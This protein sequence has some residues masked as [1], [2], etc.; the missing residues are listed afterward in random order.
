MSFSWS[1]RR[2]IQ[3][4]ATSVKW[5]IE[6]DVEAGKAFGQA[7]VDRIKQAEATW[8]HLTPYMRQAVSNVCWSI[9]PADL[10][11]RTHR[12]VKARM[13]AEIEWHRGYKAG[14]IERLLFRVSGHVF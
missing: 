6:I 8:T 14:A 4:I 2:F 10:S 12:A 13:L 5:A 11:R 1:E 3:E 9:A 7:K